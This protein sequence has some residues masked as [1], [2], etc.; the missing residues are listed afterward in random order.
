[1]A[2]SKP[3]FEVDRAGLAALQARRGKGFI[4]LELL[5]NALDEDV[6]EVQLELAPVPGRPLVRVRVSDDSPEGFRELAHAYTLFAD[7]RKRAD[8]LKR[9]RFN[10]GEKL[11]LACCETAR[12]ETT[13]GTVSFDAG[14]RHE[15]PR[16]RRDRGSVFEGILRMTR[17]ELT[18]ALAQAESVLVPEGVT[19]TINGR[20]LE[21]RTPL[22]EFDAAL[23][24]EVQGSDGAMRRSERRCRVRL[25]A[26]LAGER[27]H[28]YE[29]GLPVAGIP[30]RW[31]L[32][33]GQKVPQ[34]MERDA[35]S[36][37][38]VR[39]VLTAALGVAHDLLEPE[40]ARAEWV[41][42]SLG[43][44]KLPAAAVESI[45][46]GR[47]GELCVSADPSDPEGTKLATSRGFVVVPSGAFTSTQWEAV[48][49]AGAL[50]PAGQVTPSPRPY[51]DDPDAPVRRELPDEQMTAGMQSVAAL[52]ERLV[53]RLLGETVRVDV[54]FIDDAAVPARAVFGRRNDRRCLFEFNVAHLGASFFDGIPARGKVISLVIHELGHWWSGDHLAEAYHA[55]LCELGAALVKLAL[56]EAE[57]FSDPPNLAD[58]A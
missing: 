8:A 26:P 44:G 25:L 4:V 54:V 14:G 9:G 52:V 42:E 12:I 47:Y 28:L 51:S 18:D 40:D 41:G 39:R 31:H 22:R 46:T 6:S 56:D 36:A 38:Y 57:V 13:S 30:G 37:T 27:P 7:T 48:R 3:F 17:A 2:D 1:L 32:D 35:V 16:R 24:T 11:V 53:P 10:L 23:P 43:T 20:A 55:A 34:G 49:T 15:Q 50:K 29:L 21:A 19:V 33:I 5:Q 45:V 58:A